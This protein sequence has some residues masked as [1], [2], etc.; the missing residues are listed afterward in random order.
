MAV[1]WFAWKT[2]GTLEDKPTVV[3][4]GK[5]K[6]QLGSVMELQT[7]GNQVTGKYHT[8]VGAP[9]NIEL[10]DII[11]VVN[12]DLISIVVD[13]GKY[14]SITAWVGEQT[15]DVGGGNERIVTMWH[16]VKNISED[17]EK[18]SLWGAFL[19]GSDIFYKIP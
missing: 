18:S 4:S 9:T 5:W 7:T 10:F 19:D 6:N 15:A 14:G 3:F 2:S 12:G 11:G 16:L 17:D 1:Q 8:A 13:W